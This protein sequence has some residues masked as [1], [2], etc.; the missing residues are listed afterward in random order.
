MGYSSICLTKVQGVAGYGITE[1]W[2]YKQPVIV[3]IRSQSYYRADTGFITMI[4]RIFRKFAIFEKRT[5]HGIA[6]RSC[7][8]PGKPPRRQMRA[9]ARVRVFGD[10]PGASG[11]RERRQPAF[12]SAI[13][14]KIGDDGVRAPETESG[15]SLKRSRLRRTGP[16]NRGRP[17]FNRRSASPAGGISAGKAPRVPYLPRMLPVWVHPRTRPRAV[18]RSANPPSPA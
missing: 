6:G 10:G 9:N 11:E 5:V 17:R 14:R 18:G 16:P 1:I 15:L 2:Y 12:D 8:G 3:D 4:N 7:H 13:S